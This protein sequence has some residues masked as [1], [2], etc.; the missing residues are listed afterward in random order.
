MKVL[1]FRERKSAIFHQVMLIEMDL[2]GKIGAICLSTSLCNCKTCTHARLLAF[3]MFSVP[4]P[5]LYIL[6]HCSKV[7][8]CLECL[9]GFELL[10]FV[11]PRLDHLKD[12]KGFV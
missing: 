3:W 10:H 1:P 7:C 2:P 9:W 5:E 6:Q 11:H 12:V 8:E 4:L